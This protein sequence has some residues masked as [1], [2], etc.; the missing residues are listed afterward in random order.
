MFQPDGGLSVG[1]VLDVTD[2]EAHD[3]RVDHG[4]DEQH[5]GRALQGRR[6]E[7]DH[8]VDHAP[9]SLLRVLLRDYDKDKKDTSRISA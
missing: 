6:G 2:E 1:V 3:E 7:N 5:Y 9:H 4:E 8:L